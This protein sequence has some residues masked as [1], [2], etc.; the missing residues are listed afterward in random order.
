LRANELELIR[1]AYP[2]GTLR[3]VDAPVGDEP[4]FWLYLVPRER[5]A[6][7]P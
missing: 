5:L 1:A 6:T 3:A 7:P 2:G 4:L